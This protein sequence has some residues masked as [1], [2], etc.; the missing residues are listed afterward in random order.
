LTGQSFG[1]AKGGIKIHTQWDE[2]VMLPNLVNISEAKVHD[3]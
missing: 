1:T 2:A 3:S